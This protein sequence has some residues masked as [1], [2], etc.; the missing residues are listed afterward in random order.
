[1]FQLNKD[2]SKE[3]CKTYTKLYYSIIIKYE[4]R[5]LY[6]LY[7]GTHVIFIM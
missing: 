4:Q 7:F 3:I 6:R 5:H 1:M 2:S